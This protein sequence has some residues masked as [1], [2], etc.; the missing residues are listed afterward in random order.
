MICNC[1]FKHLDDGLI[2]E[3]LSLNHFYDSGI[4]NHLPQFIIGVVFLRLEFQVYHAEMPHEKLDSIH[5]TDCSH[6]SIVGIAA[7]LKQWIIWFV[8]VV[9]SL[10]TF[11]LIHE[12]ELIFKWSWWVSLHNSV[13][14]ECSG[15]C[16]QCVL[17]GISLIVVRDL[18]RHV[19]DQILFQERSHIIYLIHNENESI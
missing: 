12:R 11:N 8:T 6:Y 14:T 7:F 13:P 10:H 19:P 16:V 5:Q 9:A 17:Y 3:F 1:V 2:E 18:Q 15:G 4:R